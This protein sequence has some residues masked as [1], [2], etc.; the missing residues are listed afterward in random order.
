MRSMTIEHFIENIETAKSEN[1]Y[2]KAKK[3]ALE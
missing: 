1:N 3:I 2:Q